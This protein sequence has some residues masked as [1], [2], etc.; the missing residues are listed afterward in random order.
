MVDEDAAGMGRGLILE[1]LSTVLI[2]CLPLLS[3]LTMVVDARPRLCIIANLFTV[4]LATLTLA[5]I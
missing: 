4:E 2:L 1:L 3:G 5:S